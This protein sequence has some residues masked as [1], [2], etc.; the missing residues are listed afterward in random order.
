MRR[1]D[2]LVGSFVLLFGA[3]LLGSACRSDP[4]A[5]PPTDYAPVATIK[6][7]MLGIIDPSADVVWNS[8][9]SVSD[10]T[11]VVNQLPKTEEEWEVVRLAALRVLEAANLLMIPGRHVARPHEKS[12]TPGVE[13]EPEIIEANINKD[14]E[15][16]NGFAKAM[17]AEAIKALEALA[18]RNGDVIVEAGGNLDQTCEN[19]HS[20]YWYPNQPL[21]PGY[22]DAG[23]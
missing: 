6:D 8:V 9:A 11:G 10:S 19:C 12:V 15:K 20:T 5:P 13:L 2:W 21:P 22:G 3:A 18:S 23:K 4:P 7:I 16:F 17:H 1:S 14:R